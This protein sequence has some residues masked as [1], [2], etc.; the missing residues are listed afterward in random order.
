MAQNGQIRGCIFGESWSSQ[1]RPP[2]NFYNH[3]LTSKAIP[4]WAAAIAE[5]PSF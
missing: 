3:T 5:S 1:M 4:I 2:G